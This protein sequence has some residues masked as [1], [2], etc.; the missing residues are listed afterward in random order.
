MIGPVKSYLNEK[1]MRMND[2]PVSPAILADLIDLAEDGTVSFSVASQRIFP[3]LLNY[4]DVTPLKI[5]ERLNV[6]QESDHAKL[7]ILVG[8]TLSKFPAKVEEYKRGKKGLIGLFMGEIMKASNGKADPEA[9]AKI[10]RS[11]LDRKE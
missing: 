9:A 5:A 4:P 1:Q 10:L 2:L 3:E 11:F 8:E 6:F 7:E